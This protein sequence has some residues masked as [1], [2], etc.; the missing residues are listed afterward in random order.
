M[1]VLILFG[2]WKKIALVSRQLDLLL[3]M[4]SRIDFIEVDSILQ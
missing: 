3:N 2:S 4:G 1:D